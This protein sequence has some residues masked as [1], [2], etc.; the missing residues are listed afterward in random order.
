MGASH[1]LGCVVGGFEV[2]LGRVALGAF[3]AGTGTDAISHEHPHAA[4]A[5]EVEW[6]TKHGCTPMQAIESATR[7]GAEA[8]GQEGSLGTVEQGKLADLIMVDRDP[9]LDITALKQVS[10]VMKGGKT[11]LFQPEY[12]RLAGTR[13]WSKTAHPK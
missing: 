3:L 1:E 5:E 7:I 6:L 10:W 2:E 8:L 9:L 12:D 11:V 13:P 4:I